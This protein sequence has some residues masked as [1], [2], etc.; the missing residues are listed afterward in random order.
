MVFGQHS[1]NAK[2]SSFD[3]LFP[4]CIVQQMTQITA[5]FPRERRGEIFCLLRNC[6]IMWRTLNISRKGLHPVDFL[7]NTV[8]FFLQFL[9][10]VQFWRQSCTRKTCIF[11]FQ[12]NLL[13]LNSHFYSLVNK[14]SYWVQLKDGLT[15]RG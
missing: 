1:K 4:G 12:N 7:W 8:V 14:Y 15:I 2:C 9:L 6:P 5:A 13:L 11:N 10:V 3:G